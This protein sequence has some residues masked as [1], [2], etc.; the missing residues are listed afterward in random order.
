MPS[1]LGAAGDDQ[2]HALVRGGPGRVNVEDL[3]DSGDAGLAQPAD[4]RPVVAEADRDQVRACA[5]RGVE[6]VGPG[7]EDPRH[8]ADA[9]T[10]ARV[11][12]DLGLPP[13]ELGAA[14]RADANHPESPARRDGRGEPAAGDAGHRRPDDRGGEGEPVGERGAQHERD[15]PRS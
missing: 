8:Q 3:G 4:P 11:A 7:V 10:L 1:G 13:D 15:F 6:L 5:H 2:V 12:G 9:E 14:R